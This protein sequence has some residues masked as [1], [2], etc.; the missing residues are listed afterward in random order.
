VVAKVLDDEMIVRVM[1]QGSV[2]DILNRHDL[3]EV[4]GQG[5]ANG[6]Q[7]QDCQVLVNRVPHHFG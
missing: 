6:V 5:L 3:V 2:P 4:N 7:I 1:T